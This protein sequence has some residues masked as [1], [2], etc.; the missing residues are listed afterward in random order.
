MI[1]RKLRSRRGFSLGE[2]LVTLVI[3]AL[4]VSAI[5]AGAT[6]AASAQRSITSGSEASVLCGTLAVELADELRFARDIAGGGTAFTFTSSRFGAG[7]AVGGADGRV[8]VGGYP[9]LSEKAYTGLEAA[10]K[11]T[12]TGGCFEIE[13]AVTHGSEPRAEARLSVSPLWE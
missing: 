12:Y 8:L 3:V 13:I 9:I 10:A 6:A 11:V 1:K 5:A 4:A 7:A 2:V